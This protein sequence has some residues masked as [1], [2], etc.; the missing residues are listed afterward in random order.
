MYQIITTLLGTQS[1]LR[2]NEDGT[3]TSFPAN[4]NNPLY[5][6]YLNWVAQGNVAQPAV[7]PAS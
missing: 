3:V 6:E 1:I 2:L 4:E 7:A 5:Q